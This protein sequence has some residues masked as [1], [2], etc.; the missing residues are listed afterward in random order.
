MY[1]IVLILI[2]LLATS[3]FSAENSQPQ[4]MYHLT[5]S[6]NKI[7]GYGEGSSM[8]EAISNAHSDIASSIRVKVNEVYTKE[9]MLK[10]SSYTQNINTVSE[11]EVNIELL[12]LST[13][14]SEKIGERFYVALEFDTRSLRNKIMTSIDRGKKLKLI[15]SNNPYRY[16]IFARELRDM[17]AYLKG[18]PDYGVIFTNGR[19]KLILDNLEFDVM[20]EDI[21][22]FFIQYHGDI[23]KIDLLVLTDQG[24]KLL[25][26]LKEGTPFYLNIK[27][28]QKGYLS[29]FSIDEEGKV[30]VMLENQ[31]VVANQTKVAPDL[32]KYDG[33]RTEILNDHKN[34]IL[35]SYVA[36]LCKR[37][38]DYTRFK[39]IKDEVNKNR[40]SKRFPSLYTEIESC[41]FSS[42]ILQ[43]NRE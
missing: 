10:N 16:T 1:K 11:E 42:Q 7:I 43:T 18:I 35:E 25:K 14:K 24:Y 41:E 15:S 34:S 22:K 23:V 29:L 40:F 5:S 6:K 9:E 20:Q 33:F 30:S 38:R 32:E 27:S 17:F 12:G 4:W 36:V 26:R 2:T 31:H 19:Y 8:R 39:I 37:E 13:L 21:E 3:V 28:S